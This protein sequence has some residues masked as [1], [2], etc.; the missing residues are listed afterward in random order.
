MR[1]GQDPGFDTA[2]GRYLPRTLRTAPRDPIPQ[3][4]HFD[5]QWAIQCQDQAAPLW[6]LK[7]PSGLNFSL[8]SASFQGS[9]RQSRIL[10]SLQ[11]ALEMCRTDAH[12]FDPH[13]QPGGNGILK[14]GKGWSNFWT[15]AFVIAAEDISLANPYVIVTMAELARNMSTFRTQA[16]AEH[17]VMQVTLMLTQSMKSRVADWACICRIPLA[18]DNQAFDSTIMFQKLLQCLADGNHVLAMGYMES[19]IVQSLTDKKDKVKDALP[20]TLFAQLAQGVLYRGAPVKHY[21]NRRQLIWVA[22]LKSFQ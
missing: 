22:L 5:P 18:E 20:K 2:R 21:T 15:R 10:E 11:W 9:I 16:E 12:L 8:V 17:M 14:L 13:L 6:N 1:P 3:K 7:T 19:F 4:Q